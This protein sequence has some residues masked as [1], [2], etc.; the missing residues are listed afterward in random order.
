MD[1]GHLHVKRVPDLHGRRRAEKVGDVTIN[2][3]KTA[4]EEGEIG[5]GFVA[6]EPGP[7]DPGIARGG[8]GGGDDVGVAPCDLKVETIEAMPVRLFTMKRGGSE[9]GGSEEKPREDRPG[10]FHGRI[11][12]GWL[13]Q[14]RDSRLLD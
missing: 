9:G 12:G 4:F 14:K 2:D 8:G 7:P 5:L 1:A 13:N 11:F 10:G 6:P 3:M